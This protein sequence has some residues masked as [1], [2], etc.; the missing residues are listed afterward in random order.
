MVAGTLEEKM[1][2]RLPQLA[3]R[4]A[5]GEAPPPPGAQDMLEAEGTAL[6]YPTGRVLICHLR[7]AL[8]SPA[9]GLVLARDDPRIP[10][11]PLREVARPDAAVAALRA[12]GP[13]RVARGAIWM[14]GGSRR[15]YGHFLM[16]SLTGLAA[17]TDL[18]LSGPAGR[19]PAYAA[20]LTPWQ[21]DLVEAAG[22]SGSVALAPSKALLFDELVYVTT[23]DHYLQRNAG[24]L[25]S[26]LK[27]I[28]PQRPVLLEAQ[29]TI[30][31]SRRSYSGRV[32][33]EEVAVEAALAA[34]G[35]RILRPER[36][37]PRQQIAAMAGCRR[38]IGASGAGLANL[39]FL[40][41]G[42]EVIELRPDPVRE[43]WLDLAAHQLGIRHRVLPLR[44]PLPQ[45]EIPLALRLRQ[46]PRRLSGRYHYACSVDLPALLSALN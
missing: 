7:N 16:D 28:Q 33:I 10:Y 17:L 32:L 9:T 39:C 22:L 43:S 36:L 23:L 25:D 27:R 45:T 20:R 30:Y 11:A 15:N 2:P 19:Y 29:E 4:L 12:T 21:A 1:L 6:G 38:L 31:L 41:E 35:V 3:D 24:L 42:A 14:S 34:C 5:R 46:L 13:Q 44:A 8:W 18:G 26:L 37:T 40:P